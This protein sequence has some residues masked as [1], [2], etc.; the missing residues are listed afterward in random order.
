VFPSPPTPDPFSPPQEHSS[1]Q[2]ANFRKKY[3]KNFIL[4]HLNVN[5]FRNKFAEVNDVLCNRSIDV[6]GLSET[7]IDSSFPNAQFKIE[8]FNMYRKDR[9]SHG[10]GL[11]LYVPDDLPHRRRQDLEIEDVIGIEHLVVEVIMKHEKIFIILV[12]RPPGTLSESLIN[13]LSTITDKCFLQCKTVFIIGDINVDCKNDNHALMDMFQAFDLC[14][15]IKEPTCFKSVSN[16]SLVDVI[17][18]NTPNRVMSHLNVNID[19][20]DFH[21]IVCV[22]TRM[23]AP[24]SEKRTITYRSYRNM[25][26]ENF[27]I[28]LAS[29]PFQVCDIFDDV[30]DKV[31]FYNAVLSDVIDQH[32]P[33]KE[34]KLTCTQVPYMNGELR[35][36]INVKAM[37]RRKFNRYPSSAAWA[38]YKMQRNRVTNLKRRSMNKYFKDRCSKMKENN[39]KEFWETISP[40][41]SNKKDKGSN[42]SLCIDGNVITDKKEVCNAFNDFFVN[43]SDSCA[44]CESVETTISMYAN[45][46]SVQSINQSRYLDQ[47]F[48][49]E[50]VT[51]AVVE[52]GLRKLKTGKAPGHD[53]IP[54]RLLKKGIDILCK[55]LTPILNHCLTNSTFPQEYKCAE[56][57]PIYKKNDAMDINN[58]RPVSVLTSTSKVLEGIMCEQIMEFFN[59]ILSPML[60]AYRKK[61]SC[62]N[63]LLK[64]TEEWKKALDNN[65]V[66]GCILMDLSKAFDLIP[67]D[68][69]V[70]KLFA[71]GCTLN[72]CQLIKSYLSNRQ[73][74]VKID[75]NYSEWMTIKSG[76]PQGSL[77]GPVLF[78]VFINDLLVEL[79]EHCTVYNYA[80]DNSLSFN[81]ANPL[82]VKETLER[83]AN[84]ALQWFEM[85]KMKA[86]PSKF[87]ALVLAKNGKGNGLVFNLP[88]DTK[89]EPSQSVKLLGMY[90]DRELNFSCHIDELSKKCSKQIN[91][92]ARLSMYLT[93]ECRLLILNSF[94]MSNMNY[95]A[96]IY[97]YCNMTDSKKLERL[98]KRSLRII[99][100]DFN[101]PYHE[102]LNTLGLPTLHVRRMRCILE[103]IYKILNDDL[104]PMKSDFFP[105][106]RRTYDSRQQRSIALPKCNSTKYGL[107]TL[108][109]DGCSNWNKLPNNFKC[110][111]N[112]TAFKQLLSEWLPNCSCNDYGCKICNLKNV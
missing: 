81:H 29:A 40:F 103:C 90:L 58:Y 13:T 41:F 71:Y 95:C 11:I 107:N 98:Q 87:Q 16:P 15:V 93:K 46:P 89:I 69:L 85:N 62:M 4:G 80:D 111:K 104:P 55:S 66:V 35:K 20:S 61:Y 83:S 57:R 33:L 108:R 60:S 59:H 65:D 23:H 63:V 21:N 106:K 102:M 91:A 5:G 84:V 10:G 28:D 27:I 50:P 8:G 1:A 51:P 88:N 24:K 96:V 56:V 9:N 17:L 42:V 54:A 2:L 78:N 94:I 72:A 36:A 19:I 75:S 70:S 109:Y 49:F 48:N 38:K 6:L 99:L 7:K 14:N 101:S 37:L 22:A 79:S 12:Y 77:M 25:N 105:M 34:K 100:Q 73:Q 43:I 74:R 64:C 86:N 31:W 68:L 110:A 52:K 18:T 53:Q 32:A 67:H 3:I 39:G 82:I 26:D 30:D 112:V 44:P 97:H 47:T 45:N 76:V 92:M